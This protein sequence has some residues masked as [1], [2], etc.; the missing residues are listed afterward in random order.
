MAVYTVT[1]LTDEND[2]GA[3]GTGLSLREAIALADANAG[4]D[5]INFATSG[6]ITLSNGQ[7]ALATDITIDGDIGAN[8]SADITISG[9]HASRIFGISANA[10][11][12]GLVVRDGDA[13]SGNGG[14]IA[15]TAAGHLQLTNSSVTANKA[16]DGGGIY[17]DASAQLTNVTIAFNTALGNGGGIFN[18]GNLQLTNVTISTS[19]NGGGIHQTAGS[20]S[21]VNTTIS[22]NAGGGI[23]HNDGSL[24]LLD[25]IVLGNVS[26][27]ELFSAAAPAVLSGGDIVGNQVFSAGASIGTTS[28]AAVFAVIDNAT[29]GG[30]LEDNGGPVQTIALKGGAN[31]ATDAGVVSGPASDARGLSRVDDPAIA[32]QNGSAHDLGAYELQPNAPPQN[33]VPGAQTIE[34]NTDGAINGLAVFDPDAGSAPIEVTL[35]V[36]HG[37]LRLVSQVVAL[38]GGGSFSSSSKLVLSG[39]AWLINANLGLPDNLIYHGDPDFFG[40][41]TLTM[42]TNDLGATGTG[43][44][45]SDTDQVTINVKTLLAGTPDDDSFTALAGNERID[46]GG[47]IDTI[48]FGFKLTD[49]TVRYAGNTTIIDGPAGSHTVLTGFEKFV[50]TDGTV[51]NADGNPLVDDLFYYARNHDVW[52]AHADADHHYNTQGWHE[53]RDPSAFFSTRIYLAANA[54]VRAAGVNPLTHFDQYGW[55]EGRAP[56]L[57]FDPR[58]YLANYADVAAAHIDPLWHFLAIGAGEG[59]LPFAPPSELLTPNGFDFVY[60]LQNNPDVAA[61]GVDPFWHFQTIGW[62]EARNPN[63]L[64]DTA[65]YLATYS[66]V[67]AAHINPLDHYDT[68][69]WHEGRDPSIDFDTTSYLAANSDVNA[70]HVNPLLHYLQFGQHEGRS[71]LADGIWG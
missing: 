26:G 48:M 5:T 40:V 66:D 35:S 30:L 15:V 1:T 60:Y 32:N 70:A 52:N 8:G 59:R 45:L 57:D 55:R 64:F 21:L 65:G 2:G 38:S 47:G 67:A 10:T 51:N 4:A 42:T 3:G 23:R 49:A 14:G 29:G 37:T 27:A 63:A 13:A 20:A 31:P 61:A 19:L 39:P 68:H 53:G 69:G 50:F 54:D 28:A 18:T 71:A 33:T 7:L 12:N 6:T 36:T 43:G 22:G 25:S 46:A 41:D 56:S 44:P 34:A 58:E 24:T 62:K 9:N 16:H 17:T 11:L